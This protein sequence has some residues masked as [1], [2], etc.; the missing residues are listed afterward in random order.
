M[1]NI[2]PNYFIYK[3]NWTSELIHI[4]MN[5]YLTRRLFIYSIFLEMR[6]M[7]MLHNWILVSPVPPRG[8]VCNSDLFNS[9]ASDSLI[10]HG[11]YHGNQSSKMWLE[12]HISPL[13]PWEQI[14]MIARYKAGWWCKAWSWFLVVHFDSTAWNFSEKLHQLSMAAGLINWKTNCMKD[15]QW[16]MQWRWPY[17]AVQYS[18][19]QLLVPFRWYSMAYSCQNKQLNFPGSLQICCEQFWVVESLLHSTTEI[20]VVSSIVPIALESCHF[21]KELIKLQDQS[22]QDMPISHDMFQT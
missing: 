18:L 13:L 8:T 20:S 19:W 15:I 4:F 17:D 14:P 11:N 3:L 5:V 7:N 9:M 16:H 10:H 6:N 22:F 21:R 1:T 2:E 12:F